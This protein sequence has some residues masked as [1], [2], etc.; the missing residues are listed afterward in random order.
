MRQLTDISPELRKR[1]L[2]ACQPNGIRFSVWMSLHLSIWLALVGIVTWLN[3]PQEA[4]IGF[5]ISRFLSCLIGNQ[6]HTLTILQHGCGHQSAYRNA[7]ANRWVGRILSVFIFMP[8]TTFTE[9]HRFHHGYL[10]D[11][12]RDPDEWFYQGGAYGL[13]AREA[14]FMP[15][16]IYLSLTRSHVKPATRRAVVFELATNTMA[17]VTLIGALLYT[18]NA[19]LLIFGFLLPMLWLAFVFNPISR[20]YEHFPLSVLPADDG[21]RRQLQHNT[22]TVTSP[23]IGFLSANIIYHVEHH[24]FPRAPFYRLPELH[25]ML[26]DYAF[27]RV[28]FPLMSVSVQT[29]DA[30]GLRTPPLSTNGSNPL[31]ASNKSVPVKEK[32]SESETFTSQSALSVVG[33]DAK[34]K[35]PK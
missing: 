14:L 32:N 27:H 4:P 26:S 16:F 29:N 6:L 22:I 15:R 8:F 13:F 9:L 7:A 33:A 18:Q 25:R 31:R 34:V 10:G 12:D 21:R 35:R 17:Y 5:L 20:G 3:H 2:A 30:T 11:P 24:L 19:N 1:A 28:R 23:V